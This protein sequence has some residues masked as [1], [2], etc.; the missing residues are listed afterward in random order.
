MEFGNNFLVL[1][2]KIYKKSVALN[3][4]G[5]MEWYARHP[6]YYFSNHEFTI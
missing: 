2:R 3:S 4:D 5:F 1:G 6:G